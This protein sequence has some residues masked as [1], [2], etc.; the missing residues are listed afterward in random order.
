[1][2]LYRTRLAHDLPLLHSILFILH[3]TTKRAHD[4]FKFF[5]F[6]F[7]CWFY[8]LETL[9]PPTGERQRGLAFYFSV[10]FFV[11]ISGSVEPNCEHRGIVFAVWPRTVREYCT[12]EA[13][14]CF[15][16]SS[17]TGLTGW[18]WWWSRKMRKE[19]LQNQP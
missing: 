12:L 2:Q 11:H 6:N 8:L 7:S 5:I 17:Y 13:L 14:P 19:T 16:V 1:M 3:C 10:S 4:F 9:Y 15:Y 18:W